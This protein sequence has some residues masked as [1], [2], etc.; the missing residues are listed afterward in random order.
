MCG[1][2]EGHFL[3]LRT[4]MPKSVLKVCGG[5]VG[6]DGGGWWLRPILV[7]SLSLG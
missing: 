5:W 3:D 1:L 7:L 4:T 2:R 6:G